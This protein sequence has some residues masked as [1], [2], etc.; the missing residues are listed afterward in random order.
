MGRLGI[1]PCPKIVEFDVAD[2]RNMG[3]N[4]CTCQFICAAVFAGGVQGPPVAVTF[5][6]YVT[7]NPTDALI[8]E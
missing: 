1:A 8:A 4:H 3:F 6:W 5:H 7:S 2:M